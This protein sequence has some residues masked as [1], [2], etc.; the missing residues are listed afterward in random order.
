MAPKFHNQILTKK[1]SAGLLS[2]L[3]SGHNGDIKAVAD[4]KRGVIA[5][6]AEWHVDSLDLLVKSGGDA[7]DMWG[8]RLNIKTGAIVFKSQINDGRE[9]V[10][11]NEIIDD[12]IR[13]EVES[14][15]RKF[16]I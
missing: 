11:E 4:L 16:L 9:G 10:L 2:R 12:E 14:L 6:G 8:A 13:Y 5:A 3:A 1:A 7:E 15:I